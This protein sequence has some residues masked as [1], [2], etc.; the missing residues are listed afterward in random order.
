[1]EKVCVLM[2]LYNGEKYISEQLDS[3]LN[4]K[5]VNVVLVIRDDGSKDGTLDIIQKYSTRYSS[6]DVPDS[7]AGYHNEVGIGSSFLSLLRY[8][9][10][11]YPDI[12]YFAFSD[13]DDYWLEDK[14]SEGVNSLKKYR[15]KKAVYF[16]KKEIVD[17]DLKHIS[18]DNFYFHYDFSDYL[19]QNQA[20]GCTIMLTRP[21]AEMLLS[22]P[23]EK[24]PQL[25]DIIVLKLALCTDTVIIADDRE[26]IKY[27]Q[28]VGNASGFQKVSFFNKDIIKKIFSSR[29]HYLLKLTENFLEH[30]NDYI[31]DESRTKLLQVKEYSNPVNALRLMLYYLS[32][33][34]E[35]KEVLRFL[36]M[37]VF[38]GI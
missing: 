1:M 2:S 23:V 26:F 11:T 15:D 5:N 34:R 25:H 13:Q 36:G 35:P 28:H 3:I 38:R 20:Y 8:S 19:T 27:R 31:T 14:M 30:Y 9:L 33:R 16:C 10:D 22:G 21:Y 24:F 17:Q 32:C 12:N 7:L 18:D 4:Q 6:I 29:R 37:L